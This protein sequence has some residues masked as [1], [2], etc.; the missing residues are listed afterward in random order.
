MAQDFQPAG[1]AANLTDAGCQVGPNQMITV[2]PEQVITLS[3]R[4]TVER[5]PAAER[6]AITDPLVQGQSKNP[7][8]LAER[9]TS[10]R[11]HSKTAA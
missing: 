8:E 10:M 6:K 2:G 1:S 4:I 11:T 7:K 3:M 5:L 9:L